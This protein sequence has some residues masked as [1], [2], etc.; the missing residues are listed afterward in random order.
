[1]PPF[2]RELPF[3]FIR[4]NN[5]KKKK[6]FQRCP[7]AATPRRRLLFT[8]VSSSSAFA[9]PRRNTVSLYRMRSSARLPP[10]RFQAA[11]P[12]RARRWPAHHY[13]AAAVPPSLF[14]FAHPRE[15]GAECCERCR[16]VIF[17]A[18]GDKPATRA[19][20]QR[21]SRSAHARTAAAKR[22]Q[23][24]SE[25]RRRVT[26]QR[27]AHAKTFFGVPMLLLFFLCLSSID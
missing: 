4:Q 3:T 26:Q 10:R 12:V 1:V 20:A 27:Y 25:W 7:C 14:F 8:P 19:D 5:A 22:R 11:A 24:C 6:N 15:S 17:C 23:Q 9:A 13:A 16:D 21:Q 2:I 18:S